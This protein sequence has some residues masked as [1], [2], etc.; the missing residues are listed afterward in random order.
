MR[1]LA[2]NTMQPTTFGAGA[3]AL[4]NEAL[5]CTEPPLKAGSAAWRSSGAWRSSPTAGWRDE[6]TLTT[7][8]LYPTPSW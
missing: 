1:R 6:A 4:G 8:D 3:H 7:T 5:H 2:T